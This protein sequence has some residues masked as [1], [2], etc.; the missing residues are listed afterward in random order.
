MD[1]MDV[2]LADWYL[3]VTFTFYDVCSFHCH[4]FYLRFVG[5]SSFDHFLHI[6]INHVRKFAFAMRISMY[7]LVSSFVSARECYPLDVETFNG[8]STDAIFYIRQDGGGF[9]N[10]EPASFTDS[11]RT[12]S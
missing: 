6:I 5:W 12:R 11:A 8:T 10:G 9:A 1:V 7:Q 2:A 3:I 4:Q